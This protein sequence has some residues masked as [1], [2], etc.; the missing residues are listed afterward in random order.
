[1]A[2]EFAERAGASGFV[3]LQRFGIAYAL[4]ARELHKF[5]EQLNPSTLRTLEQS[6]VFLSILLKQRNYAALKDPSES[7]VYVLD[8]DPACC[9]AI[10][11]ALQAATLK[12]HSALEPSGALAELSELRADLILL[13]IAL[14]HMDGFEVCQHIR[15]LPTHTRTPVA[16]LTGLTTIE[17]KVQSTL[18]GGMDFI[19]KPFNLHELALKA[20][21]LVLKSSLN[22]Q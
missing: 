1:L 13:D 19:G 2:D 20:L 14:P 4:L 9:E 15:N 7:L 10:R 11:L 5:P 17:N 21:T 18:I 8:D 22:L 6:L 16:F 3:A 12:V